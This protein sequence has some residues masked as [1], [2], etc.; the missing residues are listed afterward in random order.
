MMKDFQFFKSGLVKYFLSFFFITKKRHHNKGNLKNKAINLGITVPKDVESMTMM[1]RNIIAVRQAWHRGSN[2]E[3][4]FETAN[5]KQR[6][7]NKGI[8]VG[9]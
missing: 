3:L 7:R 2:R 4:N 6:K 8:S 5:T 9:F 1:T